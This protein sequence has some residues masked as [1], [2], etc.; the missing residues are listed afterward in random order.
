MHDTYSK[1]GLDIFRGENKEPSE[2]GMSTLG[3]INAFIYIQ[4]LFKITY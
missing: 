2:K 3:G 4:H 1:T